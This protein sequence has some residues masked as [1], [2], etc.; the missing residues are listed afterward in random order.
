M[1]AERRKILDMLAEG[2][3]SAEDAERL[4]DRIERPAVTEAPANE[5]SGEAR[6]ESKK[7]LRH[8]RILVE[9]PGEDNVNVRLPLSLTRTG[10]RLLAVLPRKVTD[11]LAENGI[12][13]EV[14]STLKGDELNQAL[15]ELN[16]DIQKG[17]GKKVRIFCE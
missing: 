2:K 3:I 17:D 7:K 13:L 1:S 4:L 14:L 6:G 8:L 16:V 15:R 5:L 11:R 12:D 10:T 9:R